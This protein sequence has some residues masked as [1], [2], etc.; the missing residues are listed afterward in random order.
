MLAAPRNET[1]PPYANID[2]GA[3]AF[4]VPGD[5]FVTGTKSGAIPGELGLLGDGHFQATYAAFAS[6]TTLG[7][8]PAQVLAW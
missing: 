4:T 7:L 6:S 2:L 1:N 3:I 8:A 5:L